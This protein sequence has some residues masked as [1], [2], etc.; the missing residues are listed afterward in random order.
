[1]KSL[2]NL[3]LASNKSPAAN[4]F[5]KTKDGITNFDDTKKC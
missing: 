2:E 4:I 3:D 1:M 5:L